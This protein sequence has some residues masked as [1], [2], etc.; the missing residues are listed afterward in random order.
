MIRSQTG[1]MLWKHGRRLKGSRLL[2]DPFSRPNLIVLDTLGK[3]NAHGHGVDGL[4]P[5]VPASVSIIA[6][7]RERGAYSPVVG[8]KPPCPVCRRPHDHGAVEGWLAR[9]QKPRR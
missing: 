8:M 9:K 1:T 5:R 3:L 7:T 2:A 6:L 4:L